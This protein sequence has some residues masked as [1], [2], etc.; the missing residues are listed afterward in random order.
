MNLL[1]KLPRE[2]PVALMMAAPTLFLLVSGIMPFLLFIYL[3]SLTDDGIGK[4]RR[5]WFLYMIPAAFVILIV[6]LNTVFGFLFTVE[7]G[8]RYYIINPGYGMVILPF[9]I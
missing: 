9:I 4:I 1:V 3:T 6:L 5:R 7:P 2:K 8:G